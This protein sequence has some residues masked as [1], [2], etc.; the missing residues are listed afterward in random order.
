MKTLRRWVVCVAI[1]S[2]GLLINGTARGGATEASTAQLN[3]S[4][5]GN[6]EKPPNVGFRLKLVPST[7][8][9]LS[10]PGGISAICW[11]ANR[12]L[13]AVEYD[14]GR[15]IRI[16]KDAG[17]AITT[18]H[19][20]YAY[21]NPSILFLDSG[22]VLVT[23]AIND[24]SDTTSAS[25]S[26]WDVGSGKLLKDISGPFPQQGWMK[27]RANSFAASKDGQLIGAAVGEQ[28]G[29]AFFLYDMHHN[30]Q[31]ATIPVGALTSNRD[32]LITLDVSSDGEKL[33]VGTIAGKVLL[34]DAATLTRPQHS[35][36]A[37][38]AAN[39]SIVA[40]VQFSP[41]GTY[42]AVGAGLTVVPRGMKGPRFPNYF[43]GVWNAKT[44]RLERVLSI[45]LSPVR[46]LAWSPD[47]QYLAIDAGDGTVRVWDVHASA[48][49]AALATVR[50]GM[51]A[52]AISWLDSHTLA[53]AKTTNV[54]FYDLAHR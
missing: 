36:T 3:V 46:Q 16:F 13:L 44:A 47:G 5:P 42:L 27:N 8:A 4:N 43:V 17:T 9:P 28:L 26:L 2:S 48:T 14:W 52:A 24:G 51:T 12:Q 49:N 11:D 50:L 35:I 21:I 40:S 38:P 32:A 10:L 7:R 45:N 20:K 19:G 23:A 34:F 53:V 25:L 1:L 30:R 22:N 15:S 18:I 31:L 39:P 54:R 6:A 37:F 29:N 41:D 33:A